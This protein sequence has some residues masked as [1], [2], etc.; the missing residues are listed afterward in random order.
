MMVGSSDLLLTPCRLYDGMSRLNSEN[1]VCPQ[2]YIVK[3]YNIGRENDVVRA[4]ASNR[5]IT[6][7][8]HQVVC[9]QQNK[10]VDAIPSE[11]PMVW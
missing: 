2:I 10:G 8:S 6:K 11:G 4:V 3:R 1:K 9:F 5:E 7:R